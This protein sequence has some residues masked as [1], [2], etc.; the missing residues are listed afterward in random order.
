MR[1]FEN[2]RG[3]VKRFLEQK[4]TIAELKDSS[5]A[6]DRKIAEILGLSAQTDTFSSLVR[7][8]AEALANEESAEE[9][10]RIFSILH[11][12]IDPMLAADDNGDN[13]QDDT[14][15]FAKE[16]W[17]NL[18][19]QLEAEYGDG[20]S[21]VPRSAYARMLVGGTAYT[22]RKYLQAAF[23]NTSRYPRVLVAQSLV[24]REGLNLHTACRTVILLH[25]EWNPGVVEQQIGRVDR[26]GSRW[27]ELLEKHQSHSGDELPRINVRP[28]VFE[29]TYDEGHWSVLQTRWQDLRAQLHGE[30]I[31]PSERI[32]LT[33]EEMAK[34]KLLEGYAP[35]FSPFRGRKIG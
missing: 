13:E 23:N 17:E 5:S 11:E 15:E 7:N 19:E 34:V 30:V 22:S 9:N 16:I 35:N 18:S 1:N 12:I 31:P 33:A 28:V 25:L 27:A 20:S 4:S 29:G 21:N 24:G 10:S 14:D 2:R 8:V 6:Q 32:G 26:I 3:R